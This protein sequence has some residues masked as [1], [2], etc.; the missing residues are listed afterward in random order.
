[1]RF[2]GLGSVIVLAAIGAAVAGAP[3]SGVRVYGERVYPA[4]QAAVTPV[5]NRAP[6]PLFDA[7][8]VA[9][10]LVAIWVT[11]RAARRA[12]RVRSVR[13]VVRVAG[14]ALV[15][16][17][18]LYLWFLLLWGYN[19]R[20]PGVEACVGHFPS[21]SRHAR[22]GAEADGAGG[23]SAESIA[24]RRSSGRAFR[25]LTPYRSRSST[26]LHAVE[27]RFGRQRPTVGST[28][29]RPWTAPY[30]RAV[31]VSGMLAPWFLETYLNPDLTGPER[32]Y[33]LAHEWAHLSGYAPEE[34]ASFVGLLT[35]FGADPP[36]QYSAWLF[37]LSE[38]AMRLHPVTRDLVLADLDE[39]PRARPPG[40]RRAPAVPCA[41]ARS[42]ELGG[43]RP[44]HQIAGRRGRRGRLRARD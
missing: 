27:R 23:V 44:R 7:M 13:P 5:S 2:K 19:Y 32:P 3:A 31:G 17:A 24:R 40:H 43:L 26:S 1:M 42:R 36:S 14:A 28:P 35:A 38:A 33:V 41:V 30:M 39:G 34:D 10:M 11:A 22:A 8:L 25:P 20:R 16:A 9:L 4:I 6:V 15:V 29:K 21:R 18:V 37:L 12:W